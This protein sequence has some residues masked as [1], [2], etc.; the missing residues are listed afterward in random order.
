MEIQPPGS[1]PER[2]VPLRAP[3]PVLDLERDPG[4][5]ADAYHAEPVVRG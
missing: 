3:Q 1:A 5:F 2:L 4:P